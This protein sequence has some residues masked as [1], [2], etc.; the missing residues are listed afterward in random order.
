[1]EVFF[2]QNM[3]FHESTQGDERVCIMI[4]DVAFIVQIIIGKASLI[5]TSEE[6]G[7]E[8]ESR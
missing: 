4:C 6:I 5:R 2:H 1:M 3:S 8:V 7:S